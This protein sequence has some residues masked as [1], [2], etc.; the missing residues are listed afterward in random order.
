MYTELKAKIVA[1]LRADET[2]T[3]LLASDEAIYYRKPPQARA[4]PC[5]TYFLEDE[6]DREFHGYGRFRAYLTVSIWSTSGD[7]ND[8]ILA[9][10]DGVLFDAHR[11]GGLDTAHW[12][13]SACRRVES[14]V[15]DGGRA[16]A[17]GLEIERR[18]TRWELQLRVTSDE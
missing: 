13:V 6:P 18:D 3:G 10:L 17:A 2:L 16:D 8:A 4:L 5:L 14:K 12:Q 9:A 15:A 11:A 7:T 1:L